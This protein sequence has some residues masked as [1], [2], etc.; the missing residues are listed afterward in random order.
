[1]KTGKEFDSEGINTMSVALH[2]TSNAYG[3]SHIGPSHIVVTRDLLPL[4]E[5]LLTLNSNFKHDVHNEAANRADTGEMF[6]KS[7]GLS[8]SSSDINR[9]EIKVN[10]DKKLK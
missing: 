3:P 5:Q 7:Q 6:F 1:M 2:K 4:I 8:V 9:Y 10:K